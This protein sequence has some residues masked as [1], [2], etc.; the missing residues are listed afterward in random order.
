[1]AGGFASDGSRLPRW[2]VNPADCRSS[3]YWSP[4]NSEQL[5][6]TP[7]GAIV[8]AYTTRSTMHPGNGTH[9]PRDRGLVATALL[10][11]ACASSGDVRPPASLPQP[12]V[13]N[14]LEPVHQP[15][16]PP[17]P[18]SATR[19]PVPVRTSATPISSPSRVS[20]KR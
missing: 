17:Q 2:Q 3:S 13:N 8:R 6:G 11:A 12:L 7:S 5:S 20:A 15:V 14:E 9:R 10:L 19:T 18:A 1:M 16:R 4:S